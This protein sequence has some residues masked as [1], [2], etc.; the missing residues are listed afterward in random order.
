M[1]KKDIKDFLKE[2][3]SK[4][5][6]P[7][8]VEIHSVLEPNWSVTHNAYY[9]DEEGNRSR[10]LDIHAEKGSDE[11][12]TDIF[13][14][15]FNLAIECKKSDEYAWIF[16]TVP[17]YFKWLNY[18]QSFDDSKLLPPHVGLDIYIEH[19][20]SRLHYYDFTKVA[21]PFYEVRLK[22]S[23]RK[24]RALKEIYEGVNGLVKFI[25]YQVHS[26][27]DSSRSRYEEITDHWTPLFGI[28]YFFPV[29]VYDGQL[30]EAII[31]NDK[32][33]LEERDHIL[34]ERHHRPRYTDASLTYRID[35]VKREFF[36][37]FVKIIEK[38]IEWIQKQIIENRDKI[39]DA[40][41]R[42]ADTFRKSVLD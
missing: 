2:E 13:F 3:I 18:G 7:L 21:S 9:L 1:N 39:G 12:R 34:L 5:G 31:E 27:I 28:H 6:Y 15:M 29:L 8:E 24:R 20:K 25:S 30:Y 35:V 32:I 22:K 41:N 33:E 4:S 38:D 26:H 10:L 11:D 23:A 16:F 40:S 36:T 19:S 17:S 42:L 14:V 37:E